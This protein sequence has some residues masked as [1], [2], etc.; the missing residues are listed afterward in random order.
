M[1]EDADSVVYATQPIVHLSLLLT[2]QIHHENFPALYFVV[3][4]HVLD[5]VGIVTYS[6]LF[7]DVELS[8]CR[9]S[10]PVV[11]EFD[12]ELEAD[13]LSLVRSEL[14]VVFSVVNSFLIQ[15]SVFDE[16]IQPAF[17]VSSA[18]SESDKVGVTEHLKGW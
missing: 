17:S 18:E 8:V 6:K 12:F 7:A 13:T 11:I 2:H 4:T 3:W 10:I 14:L 1:V 5:F 16:D 9:R 15:C